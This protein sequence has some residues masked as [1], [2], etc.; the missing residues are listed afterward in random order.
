[1]PAIKTKLTSLPSSQLAA[2]AWYTIVEAAVETGA[3]GKERKKK[4]SRKRALSVKFVE[5]RHHRQ[6]GIKWTALALLPS[7]SYHV[8]MV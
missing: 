8:L 5:C 3:G 7:F 1:V 6:N 2:A 4:E